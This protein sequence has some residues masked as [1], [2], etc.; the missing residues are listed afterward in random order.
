LRSDSFEFIKGCEVPIYELSTLLGMQQEAVSLVVD[1]TFATNQNNWTRS[2]GEQITLETSTFG[3]SRMVID[4]RDEL[5]FVSSDNPQF[6]NLQVFD[7]QTTFTRQ[8]LEASSFVGLRF[9]GDGE[10]YYEL[11]ILRDCSLEIYTVSNLGEHEV[12]FRHSVDSP[13]NS[14]SDGVQD[15]LILSL[16]ASNELLITLNDAEPVRAALADPDGIFIG[17]EI[18]LVANKVNVA[19]DFLAITVP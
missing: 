10:N 9:R 18:E 16:N 17:G 19:F 2:D 12:V 1:E 5:V 14:C 6:S 7:L 15:Y 8:N 13:G 4:A 11:R 3:E